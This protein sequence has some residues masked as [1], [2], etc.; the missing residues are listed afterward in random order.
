VSR[1]RALSNLLFAVHG[2]FLDGQTS[3]VTVSFTTVN[4]HKKQA[5]LVEM[6]F[7][8]RPGWSNFVLTPN[9]YP[10]Y[11]VGPG[12]RGVPQ[13]RFCRDRFSLT[14]ELGYSGIRGAVGLGYRS[15][16]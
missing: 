5:T 8:R 2:H 3:E 9:L 4:E 12:S 11:L 13:V 14:G 16:V 6:V 7:T 10:A 15:A 1:G